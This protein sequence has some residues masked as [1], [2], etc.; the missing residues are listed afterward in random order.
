MKRIRFLAIFLV[1]LMLAM[2]I[3]TAC[4]DETPDEPG[5]GEEDETTTTTKKRTPPTGIDGDIPIGYAVYETFNDHALGNF[6]KKGNVQSVGKSGVTYSVVESDNFAEGET[7][8]RSLYLHRDAGASG[9][10]DGYINLTPA[11]VNIAN[12]YAVEMD[13]MVTEKTTGSV[14]LNGRKAG[15]TTQFNNFITY[16]ASTGQ[17]TANGQVAATLENNKW[18]KITLMVYDEARYYDVYVD[19]WK[20]LG[21][22]DYANAAYFKRSET[23]IN[24]YRITMSSGA[25]ETDFYLDNLAIYKPTDE[26]NRPMDYKGNNA[27]TYESIV[28]PAISLFDASTITTENYQDFLTNILG[29][30]APVIKGFNGAETGLDLKDAIRID[31]VREDGL[32]SSPMAENWGDPFAELKEGYSQ[33]LI[34]DAFK[35]GG[36]TE[37]PKF[38]FDKEFMISNGIPHREDNAIAGG[39]SKGDFYDISNYST[40]EIDFYM[41]EQTRS[42]TNYYRFMVYI[43]SGNREGG[44]S[45]FNVAVETKDAR[46]STG[47]GTLTINIGTLG[48]TRSATLETISGIEFRFSGW[49]NG[50]NANGANQSDDHPIG[51]KAIR[52]TGSVKVPVE[53]PAEGMESC[54]HATEEGVSTMTDSVSVAP[55]CTDYG[56]TAWKCTLCGKTTPK[57]PGEG[58]PLNEILLS[59]VG[60]RYGSANEVDADYNERDVVYP[61]C[62]RS[63]SASAKCLDCGVPAVLETYAA[64]GHQYNTKINTVKKIISFECPICGDYAESFF[65][66]EWPNIYDMKNAIAEKGVTIKG[67]FYGKEDLIGGESYLEGEGTSTKINNWSILLRGSKYDVLTEGDTKF[68]RVYNQSSAHSYGQIQNIKTD[69]PS[70]VVLE[71]SL[72]TGPMIDGKYPNFG[73]LWVRDNATSATEAGGQASFSFGSIAD[74]MV[75]FTGGTYTVKLSETEFTHIAIVMHFGSN[76]IDVYVNGIMTAK[77]IVLCNNNTINPAAFICHEFRII[78]YSSA[79]MPDSW[80]DVANAFTYPASFPAIFTG[81]ELGD[82][83]VDFNGDILDYTFDDDYVIDPETVKVEG[84]ASVVDNALLV[85]GGTSVDFVVD[86]LKRNSVYVITID[87]KGSENAMKNGALLTGVKSNYYGETLTETILS[88]DADGD[89]IFYN[90]IIGNTADDML[91]EIAVNEDSKVIDVYVNGEYVVS[92]WFVLDDYSNAEDKVYVTAYTFS[93]TADGE[94]SIDSFN[95]TTGKY[96]G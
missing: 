28:M 20:V 76:T 36:F 82:T 51:I 46:F 33:Y 77:D 81:V 87:F 78:Q 95:V 32:D 49:S 21:Q 93:C 70:D 55:T 66:E 41:P 38:N 25:T 67:G 10:T 17:L 29:A 39:T 59:A 3:L 8:A 26:N 65:S 16:T 31:Q 80:I 64:L 1:L 68:M 50:I 89:I 62:T 4:K 34:M 96:E 58:T 5:E 45:Y 2:P 13:L 72:R 27:T 73:D 71:L 35:T 75:K 12:V 30:K 18:Y 92:G 57:T 47:F 22:V 11:I 14:S 52:L 44:I 54:T 86:P 7:V 48:A 85:S 24:L 74:G 43:P 63:G 60:H 56:Y 40:L 19:G 37:F 15:A 9:E 61:T 91:I 83:I 42:S 94:Y 53:D 88:V 23:D 79:T 90:Q 6:N 84:T 69:T